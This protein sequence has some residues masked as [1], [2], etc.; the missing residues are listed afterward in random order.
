MKNTVQVVL[1]RRARKN[2]NNSHSVPRIPWS[3]ALGISLII[4]FSSIGAAYIS[5]NLFSD[6]PPLEEL[7]YQLDDQ[8]GILL[9]PTRFYDR[10][11]TEILATLEQPGVKRSW[12]QIHDPNN[13]EN[14]LDLQSPIARA[15][16][17]YYES[18]SSLNK[19]AFSLGLTNPQLNSIAER[20][21]YDLLLW[22]EPANRTKMLRAKILSN[23]I[24]QRY[25][26]AQT[27]T[28]FLNST[29]FG[30]NLYGANTASR[31]YFGKPAN[32]LNL[33]ESAAMVAISA[34][35]D[36]HPL[37]AP[38][39]VRQRAGEIL[40]EMLKSGLIEP[41]ELSQVNLDRIQF[42]P[43]VS[44]LDQSFPPYLALIESQLSGL[45]P[46]NRLELGGLKIIT[47]LDADLQKNSECVSQ[48]LITRITQ[49]NSDEKSQDCPASLLLPT[50]LPTIKDITS[51][52][53]ADL[54]I[55][56]MTDGQILALVST[57]QTS[58][59]SPLFQVSRLGIHPAG[60]I[61]SPLLYL[62]AFARGY[63]PASLEW[64][65][66]IAGEADLPPNIDNQYHGPLRARF[67][68]TNDLF[69]PA[70]QLYQQ[71]GDETVLNTT[72]QLGVSPQS[73]INFNQPQEPNDFIKYFGLQTTLV[74]VAQAYSILGNEGILK[75][76]T[77]Q[78]QSGKGDTPLQPLL[79]LS[80]LDSHG[81]QL[82]DIPSDFAIRTQEQSVI[83]PQLAYLVTDVLSDE[84]ARWLVFG[85]PNLFEIGR[86]AASKLG[87]T[88]NQD[89][90]WSVGY[91]PQRLVG[92]WLGQAET[93]TPQPNLTSAAMAIWHALAQY[94]TKD[95]PTQS[96]A[97]PAGINK[98]SVC[99]PSGLLPD[100]D[101]PTTVSEVF[102]QGFEPHQTDNLFQ[103]IP[104]NEQ[105]GR[106]ATI[107][108]PFEL[109]KEKTFMNIPAF[110]QE[111]AQAAGIELPPI[112]YD[113]IQ[114]SLNSS[115]NVQIT[116]P[117]MLSFVHGKIKV[118]GTAQT[119]GFR[120]YRL[121]R[122]SGLFPREWLQIGSDG[123]RAVK[124]GQLGEWDTTGLNG[125]YTLQLQV[126][127]EQNQLQTAFVQVTVDNI[128]PEISIIYP[129][130]GDVISAQ[131]H[132]LI[133]FQFQPTDEIG[134][135]QVEI[136]LDDIN[137]STIVQP[138]Y[139]YPWKPTVGKHTLKA[140]VNDQA[141]NQ[142]QAEITFIV[143][144]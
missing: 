135:Q 45:F 101:C 108:T 117:S 42:N 37:N 110:A 107:F 46:K 142:S 53:G 48:S 3:A 77:Q 74:D 76:V 17:A 14:Y 114:S 83:S 9:Q 111:W 137:I 55:L 133:T 39:I 113:V 104:V 72:D 88:L 8:N 25:G 92:V 58:K 139:A 127:G 115:S 109:V 24:T 6:L 13:Q 141:G 61:L 87:R 78:T 27:L 84:A 96:W 19:S 7:S 41:G 23:Q 51:P 56:D 5:I 102:I 2:K 16:L 64:D 81:N 31:V 69:S 122:G 130:E 91:T 103:T 10:N 12:L 68:L 1:Y 32:Q 125:L 94:S 126:V 15:F 36:I 112:E 144:P 105:T 28:W 34:S 116:S 66:P 29:K 118:L 49:A 50:I 132:R 99:D 59:A 52:L 119:E 60:S 43:T 124:Q 98:V 71:I 75:G 86:S 33:A 67:A 73:T 18:N 100:Q 47:T 79:I 11:T 95:L 82:P 54:I 62:S 93:V 80:I 128:S 65:I 123:S 70:Y 30:P 121:Q 120:Y 134:I 22:R 85:H 143:S 129:S 44:T 136:Y 97:I 20:L 21:A 63:Q 40:S 106:L 131:E 26:A 57:Q 140:V 38:Q 138:P 90:V 4:V 35:P 89:Q